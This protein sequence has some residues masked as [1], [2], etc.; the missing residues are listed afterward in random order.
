MKKSILIIILFFIADNCSAQDTLIVKS[1]ENML[2]KVIEINTLEVKYQK[3]ENLGGP[4]Y[5]IV[6]SNLLMIRYEN[7]T[8]DIFS[9]LK[10]EGSVLNSNQDLFAQG[11]ADASKNYSG[12]KPAG[13]AVLLTTSIPLYGVFLGAVPAIISASTKPSDVNL[14]Y[15][16]PDLMKNAEYA[17]GYSKKAKDIK[18]GKVL[19]NYLTGLAVSAGTTIVLFVWA[20]SSIWGG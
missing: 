20:V 10:V 15:K 12:Y 6:K 7:G 19:R 9:D 18:K 16:N 11:Q 17:D 13:T 1:G 2:A 14:G 4:I 5:T 8:K 3:F